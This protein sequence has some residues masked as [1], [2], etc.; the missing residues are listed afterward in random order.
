MDWSVIHWIQFDPSPQNLLPLLESFLA[1]LQNALVP[2]TFE[3]ICFAPLGASV[4]VLLF[5]GSEE[6]LI[7]IASFKFS[8]PTICMSNGPSDAI[9]RPTLSAAGLEPHRWRHR[10]LGGVTN[11]NLLVGC[12]HAEFS[13]FKPP[14]RRT[15]KHI[16][17]FSERPTPCVQSP[18]FRHYKSTHVVRMG[19]LLLP[20]VFKSPHFCRTGWGTRQLSSGELACAF[21]LPSHCVT[22][23]ADGT[24]L[25]QLFP[26]K[27]LSE[28][29]Q[30]VLEGLANGRRALAPVKA[31]R[32]ALLGPTPDARVS[33]GAVVSQFSKLAAVPRTVFGS[34]LFF[35]GLP[36]PP[37]LACPVSGFGAGTLPD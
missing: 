8:V 6:R 20:V 37:A 16:L 4:D 12:R 36:N 10:M 23:V 11:R 1:P 24:L 29:L 15:V 22:L 2:A 3:A 35:N 34:P 31:S 14:L 9:Q 33:V 13:G 5:S 26:L 19:D 27:L 25:P 28:P 32:M 30:Y 18:S 17:E 7:Q 21:D